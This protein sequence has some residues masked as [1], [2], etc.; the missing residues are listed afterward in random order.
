VCLSLALWRSTLAGFSRE[1]KPKNNASIQNELVSYSSTTR[2]SVI[3]DKD[4]VC[5]RRRR[6]GDHPKTGTRELGNSRTTAMSAMLRTRLSSFLAGVGVTSLACMASLKQDV[7]HSYGLVLDAMK[8]ENKKL[9]DRVA[10]LEASV[11]AS[12]SAS[13]APAAGTSTGAPPS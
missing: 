1:F 2:A 7:E 9:S 13:A 6:Q 12:A 3:R 8:S 11:S 4:P 5:S 10:A